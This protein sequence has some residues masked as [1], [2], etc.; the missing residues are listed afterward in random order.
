VY[1]ISHK[2]WSRYDGIKRTKPNDVFLLVVTAENRVKISVDTAAWSF[3]RL[4]RKDTASA[5]GEYVGVNVM[6]NKFPTDY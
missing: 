6:N 5:H 2:R 3:P 4:R 1:F